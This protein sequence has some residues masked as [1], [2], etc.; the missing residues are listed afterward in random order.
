[1]EFIKNGLLSMIYIAK[2]SWGMSPL[3]TLILVG[4]GCWYSVGLIILNKP[5]IEVATFGLIRNSKQ[6]RGGR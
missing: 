3:G 5:V 1:M 2:F 6:V 4:M